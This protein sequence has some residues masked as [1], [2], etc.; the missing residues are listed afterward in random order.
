[1]RAFLVVL[2]VLIVAGVGLAFYQ[3]W[4]HLTVN[5]GKMAAD[6]E[7]VKDKTGTASSGTKTATGRVTRVEAADDRFRMTTA[8]D[9]EM[10]V[11]TGPSSK[12]RLNDREVK[13]DQLRADDDVKV[14][15]DLKDG[16]NLATSVTIDR[17]EASEPSPR[18]RD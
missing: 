11:Y 15:Y 16:N 6:I 12:L 7:K 17:K 14:A 9:K 13:L 18:V 5:K 10:T 3:D 1:M 8:D 2:A 4:F